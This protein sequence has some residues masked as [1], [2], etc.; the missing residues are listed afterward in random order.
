MEEINYANDNI[1]NV[2]NQIK[3][4]Y[5]KDLVLF[6]TENP[7]ADEA[8]YLK[9]ELK[10]YKKALKTLKKDTA[11]NNLSEVNEDTPRFRN[12]FFR[13]TESCKFFKLRL[14]ELQQP[15]Q[16]ESLDLLDITKSTHGNSEN[17]FVIDLVKNYFDLRLESQRFD[18]D[19]KQSFKMFLIRKQKS[20]KQTDFISKKEFFGKFK[21]YVYS[22]GHSIISIQSQLE[23]IEDFKD[24]AGISLPTFWKHKGK[25]SNEILKIEDVNLIL[26]I[27]SDLLLKS[28][29]SQQT[30]TNKPKKTLLEFIHNIEDK[31]AFLQDLKNTFPTEIGKAIKGII[32]LLKKDKYLIH[33]DREFSDVVNAIKIFFNRDIGSVQGI[34]DAKNTDDKI[35][36]E[37]IELKLNPLIIKHKTT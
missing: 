29:Q 10:G 24:K 14:K 21:A 19:L 31:E 7:L 37:P 25:F 15:K 28:N 33:N 3:E 11:F 22:L 2:R 12:F 8:F 13:I 6:L 4:S 5:P 30:K 34:R 1:E 27:V 23:E 36:I 32:D 26:E 35:F 20:L 9:R 18:I 16:P 17:P